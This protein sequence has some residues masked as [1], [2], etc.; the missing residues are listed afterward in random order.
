MQQRPLSEETYFDEVYYTTTYPDI[1]GA[2]LVG[3]IRSGREH[4]FAGGFFEG[5]LPNGL[6][7]RTGIVGICSAELFDVG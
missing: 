5:R 1:A 6:I 4:F 3:R 2:L 7:G